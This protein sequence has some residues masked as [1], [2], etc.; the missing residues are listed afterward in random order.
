M[1]VYK[2]E[3]EKVIPQYIL[4]LD[5][6]DI[7]EYANY[8]FSK[9]YLKNKSKLIRQRKKVYY[10]LIKST[11]RRIAVAIIAATMMGSVTAVAYEP[12][13]KAIKDFFVR[14]FNGYSIVRP[15]DDSK[16]IDNHKKTIE[17]EY[18]IKVPKEY[19]LSKD[20]SVKTDDFIWKNYYTKDNQSY[21]Y[22]SQ[23][24]KVYYHANVDNEQAEL[25]QKFDKN[26]NEIL[27]YSMDN[28]YTRIIWDNGEYIFELSG[29]F[30][31][32]ELME[33]YYS[34]K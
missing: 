14:M 9:K 4:E 3:L 1:S 11:G 25:I 13:R 17:K 8:Q 21:V 12:A 30:S 26:Q 2:H 32:S 18:N 6:V 22:F 7:S 33:I 28:I 29:T 34:L 19:T 27:V 24:T 31:E 23:Y 15:V 16:E 10:P 20:E 5:S